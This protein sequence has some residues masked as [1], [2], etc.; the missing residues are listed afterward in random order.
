[1]R[2]PMSRV[3]SVCCNKPVMDNR[4]HTIYIHIYVCIYVYIYIYVYKMPMGIL[5]S[6][7]HVWARIVIAWACGSSLT[8]LLR[9]IQSLRGHTDT[10]HIICDGN[11]QSC[12]DSGAP[13][14]MACAPPSSP[15]QSRTFGVRIGAWRQFDKIAEHNS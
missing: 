2:F 10:G 5:D 1:M 12:R 4:I 7:C 11:I 15:D 3:S 13:V 8:I 14:T 9:M 6:L